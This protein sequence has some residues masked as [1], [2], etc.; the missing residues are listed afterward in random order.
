M[1]KKQK[2]EVKEEIVPKEKEKTYYQAVGRRREATARVRLHIVD[3][4]EFHV[5]EAVYKKGDIVV[6]GKRIEDFFRGE[7][8]PKFYLEPFR[9]TNTLNRFVTTVKVSGGG[10]NG[11]L[12]AIIHGISRALIHVDPERF[13]PILRK[14]GFMTRDP[15]KKERRKAGYAGK[16]RARKQSP[17]R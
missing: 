15:R 8:Y 16:A 17:K 5:G 9:T 13:R 2:K 10:T 4:G 7:L 11:Q 1:A 12:G 3:E 6:N 14:R